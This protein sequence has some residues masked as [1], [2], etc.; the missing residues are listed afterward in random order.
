MHECNLL[1]NRS[2]IKRLHSNLSSC[3]H[4]EFGILELAFHAMGLLPTSSLRTSSPTSGGPLVP[5]GSFMSK[6]D[7]DCLLTQLHHEM[8]DEDD[9]VE[10]ESALQ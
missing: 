9:D 2:V 10:L 3:M 1:N 6:S 4:I 7:S 5:S 8:I